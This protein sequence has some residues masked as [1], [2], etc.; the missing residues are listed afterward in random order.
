MLGLHL[1]LRPLSEA[2]M[3]GTV[4]TVGSKAMG[5]R[6]GCFP[7]RMLFPRL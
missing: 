2:E 1:A 7:L 6:S 3:V 4:G 5:V